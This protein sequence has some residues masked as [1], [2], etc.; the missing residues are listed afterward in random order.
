MGTAVFHGHA[1]RH[2]HTPTYSTWCNM[3]RRCYEKT[4]NRYYCYGAVGT[5]VCDRWRDSFS[6]FLFDMG[7]KPSSDYSLDRIDPKGNYEPK[8]CRWATRIEQ[9][10]TRTG[11]LDFGGKSLRQKCKELK[12]A[13]KAAHFRLKHGLD[14]LTPI[15]RS[16]YNAK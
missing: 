5:S 11:T 13:Y 16:K 14:P 15:K 9:A 4:N 1:T 6:D 7:P 3:R 2:K 8:N 12:I 10:R